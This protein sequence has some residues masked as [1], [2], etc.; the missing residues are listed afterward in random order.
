MSKRRRERD[1]SM[2]LDLPESTEEKSVRDRDVSMDLDVSMDIDSTER[3]SKRTKIFAGDMDLASFDPS[4]LSDA[5]LWY[6]KCLGV[7]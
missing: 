7:R 1:V 4:F 3:S 5:A 2:D 6:V